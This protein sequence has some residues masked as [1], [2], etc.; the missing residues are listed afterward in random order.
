M[1]THQ[2]TS[3][4]R[5]LED[6]SFTAQL[7]PVFEDSVSRSS[8]ASAS[9]LN[10]EVIDLT[11]E[12]CVDE[13]SKS[14]TRD[15]A[16]VPLTAPSNGKIP[17]SRSA[18]V[19]HK[20]TKRLRD[21]LSDP[22]MDRFASELRESGQKFELNLRALSL[23][24]QTS[25][26]SVPIPTT[27]HSSEIPQPYRKLLFHEKYMTPRLSEF[28]E[29]E[30]QLRPLMKNLADDVLTRCVC[31]EVEGDY[32]DPVELYVVEFGAIHIFL[33]NI[34]SVIHADILAGKKPFGACL[35]DADIPNKCLPRSFFR[36][37]CDKVL[38]GLFKMDGLSDSP[39]EN[40]KN[41]KVLYGRMNILLNPNDEVM[42]EVIEILPPQST[43]KVEIVPHSPRDML[44]RKE[45]RGIPSIN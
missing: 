45:S 12:K 34:P 8:N 15:S 31:L 22:N 32:S 9:D 3:S 10:V 37:P 7:K 43:I 14:P 38:G 13:I 40:E 30:V 36:I 41:G 28:Y 2:G 6:T 20:S 1:S 29:R 4:P 17:R 42:A 26:Q 18:R 25:G 23:Y 27:V 5:S 21:T 24:Y 33:K 11:D 35:V 39:E 19:N 44:T 16:P